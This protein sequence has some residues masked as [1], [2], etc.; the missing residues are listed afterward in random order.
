MKGVAV[1]A[2]VLA[3]A[4]AQPSMVSV[5]DMIYHEARF[6]RLYELLTVSGLGAGMQ[7]PGPFTVFGKTALA[8]LL[9][10]LVFGI[11]LF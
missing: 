7:Q 1:L 8:R 2:L 10:S 3:T 6:S 11:I 4:L 9:S 5:M